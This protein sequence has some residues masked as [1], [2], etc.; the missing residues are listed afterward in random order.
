MKKRAKTVLAFRTVRT[1]YGL[2][3]PFPVESSAMQNAHDIIKEKNEGPKP[4][5]LP[6]A[7]AIKLCLGKFFSFRGCATRAE[8]WWFM[9]FYLASLMV[10]LL[11]VAAAKS[12]SVQLI[13]F[14]V[15]EIVA[16]VGLVPLYSAAIRRMHDI[17]LMGFFG[18]IP[19]VGPILW[20][21]P[22]KESSAYRTDRNLHPVLDVIGKIF[23]ILVIIAKLLTT[24]SGES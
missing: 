6:F 14:C 13:F 7:R 9:L 22:S 18:F 1:A 8:F 16:F 5:P 19:I 2:S 12:S 4:D 3:A 23:L 10:S 21:L 15:F 17:G 20:L 11:F 24:L